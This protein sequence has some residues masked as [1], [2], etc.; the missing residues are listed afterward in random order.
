MYSLLVHALEELDLKIARE[1]ALEGQK[2]CAHS[3]HLK[4]WIY[5]TIKEQIHFIDYVLF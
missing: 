1:M 4:I 2:V 3:L 5:D